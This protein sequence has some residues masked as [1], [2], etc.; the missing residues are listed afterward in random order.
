[1]VVSEVILEAVLSEC[2]RSIDI[3]VG[4]ESKSEQ[5]FE[6]AMGERI[7]SDVLAR[8]TG[9]FSSISNISPLSENVGMS[10][11]QTINIFGF[12]NVSL[13]SEL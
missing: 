7:S 9:V 3:G 1:L 11:I 2:E 6:R 12:G 4:R 8:T 10:P 5:R 13:F